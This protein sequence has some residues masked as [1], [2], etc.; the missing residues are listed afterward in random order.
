MKH[1]RGVSLGGLLMAC[2]VIV[3]LVI[4]G[5]KIVPAVVEYYA[6]AK[7]AKAAATGSGAGATVNDVRQAFDRRAIVDGIESVRG[8]DLDIS[9]DRN[10]IVVGFEYEKRIRL[11]G[12]V[13]L[14]IDFKGSTGAQDKGD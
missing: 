14:V 6:I 9:K 10:Q 7:N 1:Q 13:S 11:G 2:F 8:V 4:F 3:V 12:P 5:M